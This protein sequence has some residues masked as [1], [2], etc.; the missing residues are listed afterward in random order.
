MV[1]LGRFTRAVAG[2]GHS[3]K[4]LAQARVC[5][6]SWHSL[7]HGRVRQ[8]NIGG[9]GTESK[10][11]IVS[12]LSSPRTLWIY[13]GISGPEGVSSRSLFPFAPRLFPFSLED[14]RPGEAK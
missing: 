12:F 1:V 8:G 13:G 4:G 10:R 2:R 14:M 5:V 7:G 3:D 6:A 11:E 9:W